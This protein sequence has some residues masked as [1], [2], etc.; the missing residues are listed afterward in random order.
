MRFAAFTAFFLVLSGAAWAETKLALAR[1]STTSP[2]DPVEIT[3][4]AGERVEI[5]FPI[6]SGNVWFKNNAPIV[7]SVGRKLVIPAAH[8]N[9]AGR[10]RVTFLGHGFCESQELI[11]RVADTGSNLPAQQPNFLTYTC[12]AQAGSGGQ[13]LVAGFI[14][15]DVPGN[16]A[17]TRRVLVRAVG[18]T[19][20]QFG[21]TGV[22]LSPQLAVYDQA[23]KA[24]PAEN[25]SAEE[26]A[27][28]QQSTGA[29]PLPAGSRD[30]VQ[31][32][33]LGPGAYAAQVTSRDGTVG[34][35]L[36]EIY[37]IPE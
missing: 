10:Y 30:A 1:Q 3:V 34:A 11:L 35:V 17:A 9:D 21:V 2:V 26:L 32:V 18:P 7:G 4:P 25:V 31:V 33:R 14:L 13:S 16:P 24:C 12:R 23:G 19:L 5:S 37:D 22:L 36:F 28:I 6:L 8:L 15:G 20:L 29:F 27:R